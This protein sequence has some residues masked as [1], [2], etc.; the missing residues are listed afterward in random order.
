[1]LACVVF[2]R[3]STAL[4]EAGGPSVRLRNEDRRTTEYADAPF[5]YLEAVLQ[6]PLVVLS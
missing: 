6:K 1:V 3:C 5:G 2:L 4:G